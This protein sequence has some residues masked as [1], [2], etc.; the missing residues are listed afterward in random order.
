MTRFVST[1]NIRF[2]IREVFNAD[3][4]TAH[5][6]YDRHTFKMFDMVTDAAVKLATQLMYPVLAEMDRNPPV[7]ENGQV[8]V[9][10]AV[11]KIMAEFG[12]GGWIASGFPESHGASGSHYRTCRCQADAAVSAIGRRGRVFPDSAMRHVC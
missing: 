7:L 1:R 12:Q 10:K 8:K 11:K 4:L 3:S 2:M 6:Y 9:H 5:P